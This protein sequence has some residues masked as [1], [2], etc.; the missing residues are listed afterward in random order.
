MKRY[1]V[2]AVV[3]L[4]L[5]LTGQDGLRADTVSYTVENLGTTIDGL[6]PTIT[7]I[8]ASGQVS[9]YVTTAADGTPRA[10]RYT[11]G[12]GWQYIPGLE[13]TYS[14][15]TG[16]NVN[17]DL[18]GYEL[19][20]VGFRAFHYVDGPGVTTLDALPGGT[21]AVGLGINDSGQIVGYGDTSS[22]VR[23][24]MSAPNSTTVSQLPTLP[25]GSMALV[26]GINNAGAAVGSSATADGFMHAYRVNADATIDDVGSLD[27][28]TGSS[29][30][31]A[32][33]ANGRVGG[34]SSVGGSTHAIRFDI[35]QP[36]DIDAFGS[37][38]STVNGMAAGVSVGSYLD[39]SGNFFAFAQPGTDA[40]VDL[41]TE[42]SNAPG[43]VLAKAM[44]VNEN[45]V[46][47]GNGMLNGVP[48]DFL[49]RPVAAR[50]TTPP[51]IS[52]VTATPATIFPPN[53]QTVP[54]TVAVVATDD[55]GS[56]ACSLTDI[57]GPGTAGVDYQVTGNLSGSVKAVGGRTYTFNVTCSDAAGNHSSAAAAVYVQPDTTAPVIASVS[58]TPSNIWPPKGQTVTVAVGV[59]ATDDSGVAPTCRLSSIA[60]GAPGDSRISGMLTGSV[61]AVGGTTYTFTATCVDAAG[62]SA[63]RPVTVTVPP[64]TTAPVISGL[65]ATPGF[66]WPPN[67]KLVNVTVSVSASD[68][69]DATPSCKLTS[70]TGGNAADAAITGAFTA[71][72][73]TTSG[74]SY[75]L[76]VS[77]HDAAGNTSQASVRVCISKSPFANTTTNTVLF[78]DRRLSKLVKVKHHEKHDGRR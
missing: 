78:L 4:G 66:I 50:D 35:S 74:N 30:A 29:G 52:S 69:V 43:W 73:R 60:G 58:A 51:V 40:A 12:A 45:G 59:D 33:D 77:C 36:V 72:V 7:G 26:C 44:A 34:N 2:A 19:A 32:I 54:A 39:A 9:G 42:L 3:T 5:M 22:G 21:F 67:N 8:N 1:A 38:F 63:T 46:I 48:A 53:G 70:V 6:V 15:A 49:L 47:V 13:N 20:P 37:I 16:I 25:G 64:D 17:G 14:L 75:S 27:G 56:A 23:G 41:N 31:C 57:S 62:N 18:S 68:D 24:W 65:S 76:T 71:N 61:K 10:V 11:A 55:S 28:P